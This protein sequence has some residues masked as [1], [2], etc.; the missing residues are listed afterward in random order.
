MLLVLAMF[1]LG[2]ATCCS[3]LMFGSVFKHVERAVELSFIL[4]VPQIMFSGFFVSIDQIPQILRWAQWLCSLKYAVNIA[5]I[6]EFS[7]L[8]GAEQVFSVTS[9]DESLLWLYIFI[10]CV[11]LCA[12]TIGAIFLLRW[13]SKSVF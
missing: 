2:A 1:L 5:Y 9:I 13:R 4:F 12:T 11:I 8:F 10:L 6:A 7:G 3:A